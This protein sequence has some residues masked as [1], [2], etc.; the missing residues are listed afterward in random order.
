MIE[1]KK[2]IKSPHSQRAHRRSLT[3]LLP[4]LGLIDV[5]AASRGAC[6]T[7]D[8]MLASHRWRGLGLEGGLEQKCHAGI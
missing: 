6:G 4:R 1:K 5:V 7:T 8:K 3:C 2:H